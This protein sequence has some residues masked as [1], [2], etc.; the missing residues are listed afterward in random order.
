MNAI[1]FALLIILGWAI[2]IGV[3]TGLYASIK[4]LFK[5]AELLS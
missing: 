1:I 5:L 2:V 3:F 4:I